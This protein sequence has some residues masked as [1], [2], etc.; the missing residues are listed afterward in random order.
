M[1]VVWGLGR[2]L[3]RSAAILGPKWFTQRRTR[4]LHFCSE[5]PGDTLGNNTP[6]TRLPGWGTWI[7]TKIDGVRVRCST[8]ENV[9]SKYAVISERYLAEGP[10][11]EP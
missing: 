11:F 9:N 8:V 7:R 1:V 6:E 10:G 4:D 3:R 2:R 5:R